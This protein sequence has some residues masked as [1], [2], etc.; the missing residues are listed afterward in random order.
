M[1][2]TYKLKKPF[3]RCLDVDGEVFVKADGGYLSQ[4]SILQ[5]DIVVLLLQ[6]NESILQFVDL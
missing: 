2:L 5:L 3:R 4:R 1:H 6:L